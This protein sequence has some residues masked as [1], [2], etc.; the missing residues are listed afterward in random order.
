MMQ[1]E[2]N[3]A[4]NFRKKTP[5][6]RNSH[7]LTWCTTIFHHP[8]GKQTKNLVDRVGGVGLFLILG[9][10]T[11]WFSFSLNAKSKAK[12]KLEV[13]IITTVAHKMMNSLSHQQQRIGSGRFTTWKGKGNVNII[14]L[15]NT[16]IQNIFGKITNLQQKWFCFRI[17]RLRACIFALDNFI[18]IVTST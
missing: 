14:V 8:R 6:T 1:I 9:W 16:V 10:A 13:K 17:H 4:C 12:F 3:T 5:A 7:R 18:S 11:K 15:K 2:Q